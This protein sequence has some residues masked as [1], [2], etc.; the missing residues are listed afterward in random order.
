MKCVKQISLFLLLSLAICLTLPGCAMSEKGKI[1]AVVRQELRQLKHPDQATLQSHA[2]SLDLFPVDEG[3]EG[4]VTEMTDVIDKF[5]EDFNYKISKVELTG[6]GKKALVTVRLTTI[7][8]TALARDY[9]YRQLREEMLRLSDERLTG[10]Q[11]RSLTSRDCYQLLL[12]ALTEKSYPTVN[13]T[14]QI[15]LRRGSDGVWAIERTS[16]LENAL[17]GGLLSC[18]SDPSFLSAADTL[19]CWL[20]ILKEMPQD[21]QSAFLGVHPFLS[22]EDETSRRLATALA[23]QV[24]N[25]FD[26]EILSSQE[27]S[28]EA[29]VKVSITSFDSA[30][31]LKTY[32]ETLSSYLLTVDAVIGGEEVRYEKALSLLQ[33]AIE[34]N[35]STTSTTVTFQLERNGRTWSLR[36]EDDALGDAI[37]GALE[38]WELV[39]G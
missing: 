38:E 19:D 36:D 5:F 32:E 13:S 37:F 9:L 1:K 39:E 4:R 29:T 31:I 23:T 35:T 15:S 18:L 27:D 10:K 8:A 12:K 33:S 30:K 7:D 3:E 21:Q 22:Q 26:Y 34:G 28:Y 11:A 2:A 14:T 25:C 24:K 6:Q 17:V 16:A 20:S